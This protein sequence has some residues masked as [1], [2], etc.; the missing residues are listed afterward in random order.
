MWHFHFPP[1]GRDTAAGGTDFR[2]VR[3]CAHARNSSAPQ[4]SPILSVTKAAGRDL[5]D[6]V[7]VQSLPTARLVAAFYGL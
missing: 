7:D 1:T 6:L 3:V 5:S 4:A 2:P